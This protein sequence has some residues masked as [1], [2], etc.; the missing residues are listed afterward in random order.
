M[1][2]VVFCQA[3]KYNI[4]NF[5]YS[6]SYYDFIDNIFSILKKIFQSN[7]PFEL[8][9]TSLYVYKLLP[10][11]EYLVQYVSIGLDTHVWEVISNRIL[12]FGKYLAR[13]HI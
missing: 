9:P 13:M 10:K 4:Y 7:V 6:Y 12:T 3:E 2:T 8:F 1:Y 5:I 11:R